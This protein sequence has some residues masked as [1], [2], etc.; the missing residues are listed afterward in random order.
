MTQKVTVAQSYEEGWALKKEEL[1][2]TFIELSTKELEF[3]GAERSEKWVAACVNASFKTAE[4][5]KL[6]IIGVEVKLILED[7][8]AE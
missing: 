7:Q 6:R 5:R 1:K 4:K 2:Q 8:S 3:I